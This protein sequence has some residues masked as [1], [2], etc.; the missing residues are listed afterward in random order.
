MT[1]R[2]PFS[3]SEGDEYFDELFTIAWSEQLGED[4]NM[5]NALAWLKRWQQK[6]PPLVMQPDSKE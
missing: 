2:N 1:R 3:V 5:T 6:N 4:Q